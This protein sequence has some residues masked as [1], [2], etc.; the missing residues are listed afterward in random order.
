MRNMS[1]FL[2]VNQLLDNR[3]DVTRRMGWRTLKP[4]ALVRAVFKSQ[5]LRKG[6]M[7][8]PLGVIRIRKI[9]RVRLN[10][11]TPDECRR[12]GF[13]KFTPEQFVDLFCREMRCEEDAMVTRI[14]FEFLKARVIVEGYNESDMTYQT[15]LTI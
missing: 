13:P 10:D 12:E 5:G 8:R 11:I 15:R 9:D 14:E 6:E 2:T 7:V 4:G 3:K 1:F